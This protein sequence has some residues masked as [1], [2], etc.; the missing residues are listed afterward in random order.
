MGMWARERGGI[1]RYKMDYCFRFFD[2]NKMECLMHL[3]YSFEN[4]EKRHR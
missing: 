1:A 4:G 2:L 3:D